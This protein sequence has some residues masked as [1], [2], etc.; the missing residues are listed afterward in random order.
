MIVID[1]LTKRF[2]KATVLHDLSLTFQAGTA[3]AIIGPNGSG[4]TTLMKSILGLVTPTRGSIT[5]DGVNAVGNAESR[6]NLGYMSQIARYPDNLTPLDVI[7]MVKGLRA[8]ASATGEEELIDLFDLRPHVDKPMRALSG[9]TRQKVSAIIALM[10]T[11]RV[12]LL[13]EPTA[14]LDPI[15]TGRLK[16]RIGRVKQQGGTVL[17]TSHILSDI[18]ELAD[19]IVFLHEGSVV[20]DGTMH[21]LLTLTSEASLERAIAAMMADP[22]RRVA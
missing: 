22:T 20:Y 10:F 12:L 14:G 19:R 6:R 17:I 3:T 15:A 5:I 16:D 8:D 2:R 9:G 7:G 4:K 18:E 13:D 1:H 11:P 21:D